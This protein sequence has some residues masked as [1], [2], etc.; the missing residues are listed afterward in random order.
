LNRVEAC[1]R[2][3][4]LYRQSSSLRMVEV[5]E[6]QLVKNHVRNCNWVI[7]ACSVDVVSN[8]ERVQE[9]IISRKVLS[10][11]RATA[12][13][14]ARMSKASLPQRAEVLNQV[15][16]GGKAMNGVDNLQRRYSYCR[17]IGI[18]RS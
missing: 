18:D 3:E 9:S 10:S 8:D 14:R 11:S 4:R 7:A 1:R 6:Q 2:R 12:H 13:H 15:V 17:N 5:S 16:I